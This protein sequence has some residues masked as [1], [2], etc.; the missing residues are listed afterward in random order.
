MVANLLNKTI[1]VA[2][3]PATLFGLLTLT[4]S[5]SAAALTGEF[6]L[7]VGS[8]FNGVTSTV[9]LTSDSLIFSPQPTTPIAI[10]SQIGSFTPF[11]TASINNILSFSSDTAENPFIDFGHTAIPG[12]IGLSSGDNASIIDGLNTFTLQSSSY[13]LEQSG[14]NVAVDVVLAGFFT[15]ADGDVSQGE[16]NLTF[17]INNNSVSRVQQ[18]LNNGISISGLTFSGGLFTTNTTS[19]PEPGSAAALLA[20]GLVGAVAG[21]GKAVKRNI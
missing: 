9:S 14:S 11:N 5:A 1:K 3:I 21:A 16:G 6:Q 17:Q 4:D 12:I 15:S 18:R 20:L 2:F 8:I 7:G 10:T 19:V 13:N